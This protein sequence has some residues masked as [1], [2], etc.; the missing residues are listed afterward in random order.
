MSGVPSAFILVEVVVVV[1][2][3]GIGDVLVV[4]I[5]VELLLIV[6]VAGA[7]WAWAAKL[8]ATSSAVR[9]LRKRFM[10]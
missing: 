9:K 5:L 7:V 10:G 6:Q 1:R 3:A 4:V 8:P 2:V